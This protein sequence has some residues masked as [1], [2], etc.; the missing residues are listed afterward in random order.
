MHTRASAGSLLPSTSG[1]SGGAKWSGGLTARRRPML[2]D[3]AYHLAGAAWRR[4]LGAR[5]ARRA[6]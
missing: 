1:D 4:R 6:L 5:V 3:R 2:G